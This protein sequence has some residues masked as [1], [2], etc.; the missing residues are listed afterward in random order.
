MDGINRV[1]EEPFQLLNV[2]DEIVRIDLNALGVQ[3]FEGLNK[4]IQGGVVAFLE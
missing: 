2:G 1:V 4:L 3:V